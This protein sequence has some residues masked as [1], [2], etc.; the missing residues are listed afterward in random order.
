[1]TLLTDQNVSYKS[2]QITMIILRFLKE[3]KKIFK[4]FY[5]LLLIPK[6]QM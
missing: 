5:P 4:I 6:I 3:L 2:L 1:M